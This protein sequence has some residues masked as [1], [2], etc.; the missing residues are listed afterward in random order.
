MTTN[1]RRPAL[2]APADRDTL[3]ARAALVDEG[4]YF[5]VLGV[6]R[7][8]TATELRR[9]H[10]QITRELAPDAI[11]DALSAELGDRLD[12]MREV[13]AEALRVLTNDS[14]RSRYLAHLG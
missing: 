1:S 13:V 2:P 7:D 4:D 6:T 9:A 11:D 10:E 12:A 3:L 8:A 14:L 5:E